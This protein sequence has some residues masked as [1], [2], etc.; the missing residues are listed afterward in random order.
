MDEQTLFAMQVMSAA[1]AV[2][3]FAWFWIVVCASPQFT[4]IT[5]RSTPLR[6]FVMV[7]VPPLLVLKIFPF[8]TSGVAPAMNLVCSFVMRP[9]WILPYFV[10]AYRPNGVARRRISVNRILSLIFGF[11]PL[12]EKLTLLLTAENGRAVTLE[13]GL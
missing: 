2:T 5:W 3:I 6:K 1:V 7:V 10:C 11:I 8:E 13:G 9:V 4:V 12:C